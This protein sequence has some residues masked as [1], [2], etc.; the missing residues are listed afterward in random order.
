[1]A[2]I[3]DTTTDANGNIIIN[4]SSSADDAITLATA[5]TYSDKNIIFNIKT[6]QNSVQPDWNQNDDTQPDYV[7]NRP[8]WREKT[9]ELSY[10]NITEPIEVTTADTEYGFAM[11]NGNFVVEPDVTNYVV[12]DGVEY[13]CEPHYEET[14]EDVGIG[15]LDF[16]DYPFLIGDGLIL[17]PVAGTHTVLQYKD[18]YTIHTDYAPCLVIRTKQTENKTPYLAMEDVEKIKVAF[19]NGVPIMLDVAVGSHGFDMRV[20]NVTNYSIAAS[21][22]GNSTYNGI[23]EQAEFNFFVHDGSLDDYS[24]SYSGSIEEVGNIYPLMYIKNRK[25]KITVDNTG[26]LKA[27][28]VT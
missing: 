12:F 20:H 22:F 24:V 13:T 11:A 14:L 5:G 27:T 15:S 23:I 3:T 6:P 21:G 2:T 7:K 4:V 8:F 9:K 16:I 28:E 1:M 18:V 25:Y 19:K 17:T 26:T 10:P